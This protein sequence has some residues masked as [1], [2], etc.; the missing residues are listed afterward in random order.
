MNIAII[1]AG[2]VGQRLSNGENCL[3]KQ[4][5][6]INDKPIIVHTLELFQKHQQIDKIYQNKQKSCG[7]A[8]SSL[9]I[10][11]YQKLATKQLNTVFPPQ[12]VALIKKYDGI[13]INSSQILPMKDIIKTNSS[14]RKP[15]IILGYDD[16]DWIAYNKN[17]KHYQIIDKSDNEVLEETPNLS[18]A[19]HYILKI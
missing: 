10:I 1:F 17:T 19:L 18:T 9:D 16:F 4:F 11:K 8:L 12:F 5:L 13:N 15:Y 7:N 3:P 6:K 14:Y 2:G